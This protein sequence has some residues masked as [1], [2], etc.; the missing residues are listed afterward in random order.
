MLSKW[1]SVSVWPAL[2][3]TPSTQRKRRRGGSSG[4]SHAGLSLCVHTA[5]GCVRVYPPL[6]TKTARE[7]K[8]AARKKTKQKNVLPSDFRTLART[9]RFVNGMLTD[10]TD[11]LEQTLVLQRR[12]QQKRG[13]KTSQNYTANHGHHDSSTASSVVQQTRDLNSCSTLCTGLLCPVRCQ[14]QWL[15]THFLK[16]EGPGNTPSATN[17]SRNSRHLFTWLKDFWENDLNE[18]DDCQWKDPL[19][20]LWS[21]RFFKTSFKFLQLL[22]YLLWHVANV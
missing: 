16:S 5:Q 9:D 7:N 4:P 3:P 15:H 6:T 17:I 18:A 12:T 11:A 1:R 21:F 13:T 20:L 10:K 14:C 22:T 8:N 2:Q 19:R